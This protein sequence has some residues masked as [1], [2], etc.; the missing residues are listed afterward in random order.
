[1]YSAPTNFVK[2]YMSRS[3]LPYKCSP[4]MYLQADRRQVF[5]RFKH[6]KSFSEESETFTCC[7][8]SVK[9]VF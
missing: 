1:M 9:C 7:N 6:W 3:L 4:E 5:S 2:R 8:F